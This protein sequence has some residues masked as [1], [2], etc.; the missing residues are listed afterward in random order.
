MK[1]GCSEVISAAKGEEIVKMNHAAIDRGGEAV[2]K[3]RYLRIGL[4]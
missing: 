1:K 4:N 3:L 2:P